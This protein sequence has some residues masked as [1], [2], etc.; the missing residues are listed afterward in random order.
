MTSAGFVDVCVEELSTRAASASPA[1]LASLTYVHGKL[2][3]MTDVH[4]LQGELQAQLMAAVWRLEGGSVEQIRAA[5]PSRYRGAY[6]TVQTVLNRLAERGL[7]E[8]RKNGR[9][10]IYSPV[11]SEAEY[12]SQMIRGALAGASA[13]ARQ[14]AL[15]SLVGGLDKSEISELQRMAKKAEGQR[16][17]PR[18]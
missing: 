6:T 1:A 13:G 5:L 11:V 15:A 2:P 12:V 16:K 3:T 10:F 8:R 9:N 14:T 7:L 17:P 4:P 18:R